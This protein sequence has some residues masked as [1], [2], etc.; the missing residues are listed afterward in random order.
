MLFHGVGDTFRL[1]SFF[2]VR[3]SGSEARGG[4]R[5]GFG[6]SAPSSSTWSCVKVPLLS[7]FA[8]ASDRS[9]GFCS[10]HPVQFPSDLD[11]G[12]GSSR[13]LGQ[14]NH[15]WPTGPDSPPHT[16]QKSTPS[17]PSERGYGLSCLCR[18]GKSG[19]I[20]TCGP[21]EE[22][23]ELLETEQKWPARNGSMAWHGRVGGRWMAGWSAQGPIAGK[24]DTPVASSR[25][26]RM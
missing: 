8:H 21:M 5:P 7:G 19:A 26:C 13:A 12:E 3:F 4:L 18:R 14:S 1:Q 25:N 9:E 10:P 17:V 16:R 2:R 24:L 20:L 11:L 23:L 6:A 22:T 15:R